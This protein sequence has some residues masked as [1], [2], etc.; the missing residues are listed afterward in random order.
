VTIV[1]DKKNI[2]IG[3][4]SETE[5]QMW[6][7]SIV[8]NDSCIDPSGFV[9]NDKVMM[10]GDAQFNLVEEDLKPDE[11]NSYVAKLLWAGVVD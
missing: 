11:D 3:T 10:R 7:N 1:V 8:L 2:F 6:Q 5:V 9:C 4:T